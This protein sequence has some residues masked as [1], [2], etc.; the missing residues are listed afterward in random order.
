MLTRV[1]TITTAFGLLLAVAGTAASQPVAEERVRELVQ[2]ALAQAGQTAQPRPATAAAPEAA[3]MDLTL[4]EALALA[5]E[6]NNDIAVERLNP[7]TFDMSLASLRGNYRP[8]FSSTLGYNSAAQ[9]PTSQLVGGAKVIN[10]TGTYNFGL[11]Q[12]V[13]WHGG[14]YAVTF[15]NRGLQSNNAFN[16]FN[17]QFNATLTAAYTQPLIR[18]FGIDSTRQQLKVTQIN[19]DISDV[20]LRSTI[21]NTLTSV[22][23]AYFDLLYAR[24]ALGVARRSLDLAEKLVEDNRIR[25]EVGALAP[26][27][28]VQAEAEAATRRQNLELAI[29]ARQTAELAL[30]RLIVKD[31]TDPRWAAPVNPTTVPSVQEVAVDLE[32]AV[33][34]ALAE[35][36]DLVSAR[37]QLD[38]NLVN[39]NL[40]RNQRLPGADFVASYALQGIGGTRYVRGGNWAVRSRRQSPAGTPMPSDCFGTANTRAGISRSCSATRSGPARPRR[41]TLAARFS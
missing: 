21:T 28:I 5:L 23:F 9:L 27:D 3:A 31:T 29:S 13:P 6:Q 34:R 25:V 36:T 4:D 16:T 20:N 1:R 35:R 26:I 15:N 2:A 19:R 39:L 32:A 10:D 18:G 38:A 30:K 24:A 17:P 14:N 11:A 8:T 7:Q 22:R 41:T 33:R 40:L 12:Q 37:G